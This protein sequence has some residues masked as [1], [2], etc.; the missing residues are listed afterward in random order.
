MRKTSGGIGGHLLI[1]TLQLPL[2]S[3][4]ILAYIRSGVI[5]AYPQ[6]LRQVGPFFGRKS[7]D[8]FLELRNA[9]RQKLIIDAKRQLM[10]AARDKHYSPTAFTRLK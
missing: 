3:I 9:H 7:Q 6:G 1:A 4:F 10:I 8:Q 5:Q 2:K